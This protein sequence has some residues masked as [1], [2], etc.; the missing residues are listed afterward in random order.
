MKKSNEMKFKEAKFA[1]LEKVMPY[2]TNPSVYPMPKLSVEECVVLLSPDS[3]HI[4]SRA[5]FCKYDR[6][7]L[8]KMKRNL[9]KLGITSIFDSL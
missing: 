4:M 1:A 2:Y 7:M 9:T 8:Q 3:G 6:A 5:A